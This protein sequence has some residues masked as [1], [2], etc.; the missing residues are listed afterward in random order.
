MKRRAALL[1]LL[2][3][4][5]LLAGMLS[6]NPDYNRAVQPFVAEVPPGARGE[7]R[8]IEASFT[9]WRTADQIRFPRFG[10][11]ITRTTSGIFLI[12]ELELSG[13]SR[14][15]Q[16]N[17][18]WIGTSERRYSASKR[19]TGMTRHL[20]ETWLQPGLAVSGLAVFELPPDE[21]EGGSLLLTL[22]SDPPLEGTLRLQP[23]ATRPDHLASESFEQ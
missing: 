14:S 4:A 8:L 5:L 12:V 7:T 13:T 20:D 22:P 6:T 21:I 23:P 16:A 2:A 15:T 10:S 1:A 9:G 17:A 19:V 18:V 11:E 3:G